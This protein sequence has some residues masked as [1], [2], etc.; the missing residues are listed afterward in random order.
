MEERTQPERFVLR[1]KR[2][3]TYRY[4]TSLLRCEQY[5]GKVTLTRKHA[6]EKIKLRGMCVNVEC[7]MVSDEMTCAA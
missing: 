7:G 3:V 4:L 2:R 1:R 5:A 6:R